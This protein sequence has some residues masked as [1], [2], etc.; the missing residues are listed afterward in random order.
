MRLLLL[1]AMILT[2]QVAVAEDAAERLAKAVRFET[3]SH[4]EDSGLGV[5]EAAHLGLQSFIR[6]AYP[7]VHERL[8]VE[9]IN[10]YS[11]LIHWPGS[12][13]AMQPVLFTAHTDVVPVEPGTDGDWTHPAFA[14]VIENGVIYGRGTLDDKLGVMGLLEAA[15]SLLAQG[16][17]PE[18]SMYFGFGHDEEIGGSNG[19]GKIAATLKERGLYFEWMLDEGGFIIENYPMLP[20][21]FV[22]N[23]GV[24]EKQFLTL[25][26]VATGPG[27]HSSMPPPRSTIVRLGEAVKR[28]EDNPFP[29][30][31]V[32]PMRTS[33]ER[34]GEELGFPASLLLGNLWLTDG[35]IAW[36][37]GQSAQTGSFVRT[38]TAVTIFNAGV[39][40]N[41]VPQSAEAQINFRI[42]PGETEQS[43]IDRVVELVDDPAI[44]VSVARRSPAGVPVAAMSGGGYTLIENAVL[45]LYPEAVALPFML[46]ATTD[47]RH[48]L[49]LADNHYRFHGHTVRVEDTAGVHGTDEK[50][51]VD[52]YL[53][54]I[55]IARNILRRAGNP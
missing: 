5:N 28:V 17:E 18:R 6:N 35:L 44:E 42:L 43:V 38:S 54:L 20:D 48:Y 13:P 3:V 21:R 12:D 30:K 36:G 53:G 29:V 11:Y 45:E 52:S 27:G 32:E 14:G 9:Y 49:E 55:E 22:A 10:Q 39:K 31:L 34:T 37:M 25:R 46:P 24:A 41:V 15:E 16:Y 19:A 7:L 8:T 51:R 47:V 33:L 26:L 1:A 50:I 2:A 40:D 23:I 4:P